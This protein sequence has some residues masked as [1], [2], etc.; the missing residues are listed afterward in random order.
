MCVK[1]SNVD[2]KELT[3]LGLVNFGVGG[4][5]AQITGSQSSQV[6]T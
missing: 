5:C 1:S 4:F 6:S 2:K 3:S